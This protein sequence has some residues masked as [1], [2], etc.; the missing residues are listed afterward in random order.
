MQRDRLIVGVEFPSAFRTGRRPA[1]HSPAQRVE[2]G[3]DGAAVDRLRDHAPQRVALER[4]PSRAVRGFEQLPGL[5]VG[6]RRRDLPVAA[7]DHVSQQVVAEPRDRP[8]PVDPLDELSGRIDAVGDRDAVEVGFPHQVSGRVVL[9]APHLPE[10]VGDAGKPHFGVIAVF[11]AGAVRANFGGHQVEVGQLRSGRRAELVGVLPQVA[12]AVVDAP[13]GR[14]VRLLRPGEFAAHGPPEPPHAADRVDD[15][16]QPTEAVVLVPGGRALRV[17]DRHDQ[18]GRVPVDP[19]RVA[20]RIGD[21]GDVAALVVGVTGCRSGRIGFSGEV[22]TLVVLAARDR[23]VG[24]DV[25]DRPTGVVVLATE[26]GPV[27]PGD[28]E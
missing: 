15:G 16:G 5:A 28:R 2:G 26:L 21:T 1:P 27:R 22:A 8:D 18:P 10:L 14:A 12:L 6:E 17:G 13:F 23:A 24:F 25:R 4:H 3:P 7:L 9:V 19:R 11:Q 20:E